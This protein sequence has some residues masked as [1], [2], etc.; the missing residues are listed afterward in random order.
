[1]LPVL[2]SN[3]VIIYTM[4]SLDDWWMIIYMDRWWNDTKSTQVIGP[5]EIE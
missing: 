2:F 4:Y 1:M 3:D 5:I